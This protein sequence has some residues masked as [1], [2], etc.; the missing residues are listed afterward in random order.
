MK[1]NSARSR[2][3]MH[4]ADPTL[5]RRDSSSTNAITAAPSN[6]PSANVP[7]LASRHEKNTRAT[8]T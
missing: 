8:P 2:V 4:F 6:P 7:A 5:Q 3:T 1:R